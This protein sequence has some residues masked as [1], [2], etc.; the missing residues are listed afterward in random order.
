MSRLKVDHDW[1][2]QRSMALVR[3]G[4]Q[5]QASKYGLDHHCTT[6]LPA[7]VHH[8]RRR[9]QGGSNELDNLETL[10]V[11]AHAMVHN[12]WAAQAIECGLLVKS[13]VAADETGEA[14]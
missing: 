9:S 6:W 3:D 10:C 5:C 13:Q 1:Q 14:A 11:Q 8:K 12:E 2:L 4:G 7:H